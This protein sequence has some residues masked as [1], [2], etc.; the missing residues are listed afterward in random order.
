MVAAG[1]FQHVF[2]VEFGPVGG[3][4]ILGILPVQI[5]HRS[6][7]FRRFEHK[8]GRFLERES[9]AFVCTLYIHGEVAEGVLRKDWSEGA[10]TG[11]EVHTG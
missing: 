11:F 9:V 2:A 3:G 10:Q 7:H 6:F 1:N 8:S 4:N 5:R